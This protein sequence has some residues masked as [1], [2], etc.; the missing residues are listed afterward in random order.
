M[1]GPE[2]PALTR[3]FPDDSE[4]HKVPCLA[5]RYSGDVLAAP[6]SAYS[7]SSALVGGHTPVKCQGFVIGK[8]K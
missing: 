8:K 1:R 6:D 7:F 3:G 4:A 5:H 2:R